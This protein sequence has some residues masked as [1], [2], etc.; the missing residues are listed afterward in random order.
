[1][2]R[3]HSEPSAADELIE[4]AGISRADHERIGEQAREATGEGGKSMR[5]AAF[6]AGLPPLPG[7]SSPPL[8][9][10]GFN[11]LAEP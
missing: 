1:M 9:R 7:A 2:T 5:Q 4:A 11:D 8:R 10:L 6:D 3:S